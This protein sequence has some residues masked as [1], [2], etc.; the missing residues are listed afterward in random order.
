[1]I[2][3]R[4]SGDELRGLPSHVRDHHGGADRG[5]IADR[6]K[7]G[8]GWCS[9]GS[10]RRWCTSRLRTGYGARAA[11]SSKAS[12]RCAAHRR[13]T[14][15]AGPQFT[16]TP[17]LPAWRWRSCRQASGMAEDPDEAAQPDTGHDRR[18]SA[19][20][21]LVRFNAGSALAA[22]N[23]AAVVFRTRSSRPA[24]QV[25]GGW[26]R[27]RSAT[28]TR[29]ASAPHPASSQVWWRSPP[30]AH[31]SARWSDRARC[32]G[33]CAVCTGGRTEVQPATTTRSTWWVCTWS[34]VWSARC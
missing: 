13:S 30:R 26:S 21:R 12:A 11:G 17:V 5:A 24:R 32:H 16:S 19:V 2:R 15:Q 29:P 6:V 33:R 14:S 25:S 3:Q 9:P 18:R 7:F 22:N 31:R 1:M 8:M 23:T 20:V 28:V 27:R 4:F 10:G 34:V